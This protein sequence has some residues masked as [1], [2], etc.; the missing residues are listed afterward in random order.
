MRV[1]NGGQSAA[2]SKS[3]N[4]SENYDQRNSSRFIIHSVR[5]SKG[6]FFMQ[7]IR[8]KQMIVIHGT[9]ARD[10]ANQVNELFQIHPDASIDRDNTTPF[11]SYHI[12]EESINIPETIA[13]RYETAGYGCHCSDCPVMDSIELKGNQK[14]YP[15]QFS[16]YGKTYYTG[17]ACNRY[18]E[19]F[20]RFGDLDDFDKWAELTGRN[21]PDWMREAFER[22]I[23]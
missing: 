22:G 8:N 18:Y 9:D 19:E 4:T 5:S 6:V 3:L 11:L 7:V 16:K 23:K 13:E 10:Y 14:I 2:V 21:W 15:C 12:I 1:N 17:A 20:G